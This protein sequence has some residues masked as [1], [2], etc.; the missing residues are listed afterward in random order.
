MILK[1][2]LLMIKWKVKLVKCNEMDIAQLRIDFW[3]SQ[4][5]LTVFTHG[6]DLS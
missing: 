4:I 5:L 2:L 6:G 3:Y 1:L